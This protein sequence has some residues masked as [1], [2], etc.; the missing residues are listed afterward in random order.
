ME[1]NST[2][3]PEGATTF[4]NKDDA[5]IIA[6]FD[7]RA[8][9]FA[10]LGGLPDPVTT[11]SG[12]DEQTALW[13]VIDV[14]EAEIC[15][16]IATTARGAEL[17]LWT[18]ATYLFDTAEDEGPCYRA[19][20]DHFTAQGDRRDWKDRLALSAL[21]SLRAQQEAQSA[22]IGAW[23]AAWTAYGGS[24]VIDED[25][26]AQIGWVTYDFSPN[27]RAPDPAWPDTVRDNMFLHAQAHHDA[28]MKARYEAIRMVPGGVDA[29]KA[30]M[31][32]NGIRVAVSKGP[33]Q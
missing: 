26:K 30:H 12:T 29:L 16:S 5:A 19:D 28:T 20:L 24:V 4:T 3:A 1:R 32:A 21:R 9:A 15:T 33:D 22:F 18:A 31:R 17:Q 6:A 11:G 27:Y 10:K 8:A 23:L 25:G 14:A 2:R 7:R 13:S